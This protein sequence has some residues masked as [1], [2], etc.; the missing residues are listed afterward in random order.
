LLAHELQVIGERLWQSPRCLPSDAAAPPDLRVS[1]AIPVEACAMI[2]APRHTRRRLH[3]AD[4]SEDPG[5]DE[6]AAETTPGPANAPAVE[7]I[8]DPMTA[9]LD[10]PARCAQKAGRDPLLSASHLGIEG[11]R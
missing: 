2:F 6:L 5:S 7:Y 8:I 3:Q 4:S 10:P 1:L 11:D 9:P